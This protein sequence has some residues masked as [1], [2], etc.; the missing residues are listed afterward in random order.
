MLLY[1]RFLVA[2]LR[3]AGSISTLEAQASVLNLHILPVYSTSGIPLAIEQSSIIKGL[4]LSICLSGTHV[5]VV[6]VQ[7][8]SWPQLATRSGVRGISSDLMVQS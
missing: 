6:D 5:E 2:L 3:G 8:L 4:S 1:V 7:P